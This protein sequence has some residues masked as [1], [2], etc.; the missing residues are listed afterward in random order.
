MSDKRCG[1]CKWFEPWW[2][3]TRNGNCTWVPV[4]PRP[5]WF[6]EEFGFVVN[7]AQGKGRVTCPTWEPKP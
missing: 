1:K 5:F 2:D 3:K 6:D 4:T 7:E